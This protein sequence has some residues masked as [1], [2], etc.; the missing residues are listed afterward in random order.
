MKTR[1]KLIRAGYIHSDW[2]VEGELVRVSACGEVL[3]G[4][5]KLCNDALVSAIRLWGLS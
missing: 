1:V 2:I 4:H 3:A 5:S